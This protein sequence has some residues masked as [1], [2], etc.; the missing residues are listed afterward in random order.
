M[1]RTTKITF[2]LLIII[3]FVSYLSFISLSNA[4][5][6]KYTTKGNNQDIQQI[7]KELIEAEFNFKTLPIISWFYDVKEYK[8]NNIEITNPTPELIHVSVS[9]DEKYTSSSAAVDALSSIGE[10]NR[11]WITNKIL[12]FDILKDENVYKRIDCTH[13]P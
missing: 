6:Y 2:T 7:A 1:T 4:K 10:L 3:I 8:I 9:Y 5:A 11:N 13:L 12:F